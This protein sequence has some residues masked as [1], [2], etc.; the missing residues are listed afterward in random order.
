MCYNCGCGM[1]ADN[2]G[3]K[4][5]ITDKTIEEAAKAAEISKEEAMQ[6]MLAA[7]K[8]KLGEK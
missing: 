8:K 3:D 1:T 5:N 7:L 4:R 2:M 6:N